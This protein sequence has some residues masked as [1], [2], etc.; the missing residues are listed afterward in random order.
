MSPIIAMKSPVDWLKA[1]LGSTMD[2]LP[3]GGLEL[4]RDNKFPNQNMQVIDESGEP[5][6]FDLRWNVDKIIGSHVYLTRVG[7][8]FPFF[9]QT[10]SYI[11]LQSEAWEANQP[12]QTGIR[13]IGTVAVK[14]PTPVGYIEADTTRGFAGGTYGYAYGFHGAFG[15][16]TPTAEVFF[17][18][19]NS[20]VIPAPLPE[21]WPVGTTHIDLYLRRPG[22]VR[23]ALQ[24]SVEVDRI[25]GRLAFILQGPF[26][27]GS[28]PP[29]TN[30]SG[31]GTPQ[32][33]R[34]SGPQ[35]F[36]D[37][38]E[39]DSE[40]DLWAGTYRFG[41]QLI[42]D[43]G[44][45]LLS[46]LTGTVTVPGSTE[47]Y[48]VR[49]PVNPDGASVVAAASA[50]SASA[51]ARP[52]PRDIRPSGKSA[53]NDYLGHEVDFYESA[54]VAAVNN[55]RAQV[56]HDPLILTQALN[57]AAYRKACGDSGSVEDL[58]RE[59]GY[60]GNTA[61]VPPAQANAKKW[62]SVGIATEDGETVL[63]VGDYLED[64]GVTELY[65]EHYDAQGNRH[66]FGL[67]EDDFHAEV[68]LGWDN[69]S[70]PY[71]RW[72]YSGS[73]P[74]AVQT[75]SDRW[76]SL[77]ALVINHNGGPECAITDGSP[78]AGAI[79]TTYSDGRMIL[80]SYYFERATQNARNA[81]TA[82]EFGHCLG[83]GHVTTASVLN[84]PI[85][86][87]RTTNY[88]TPTSYDT[89]EYN[90]L[91][92]SVDGPGGG[93]GTEPD[94]N[95]TPA[96]SPTGDLGGSTTTKQE[97]RMETRHR[98]LPHKKNSAFAWRVPDVVRKRGG[99]RW[100]PW[101]QIDDVFYRAYRKRWR[102][103]Q[104][105]SF[106]RLDN[107]RGLI[108]I[109]G[110]P[111][112]SEPKGLDIGLTQTD[113][114]TEDTTIIEAPDPTQVP[115]EPEAT[116]SVL[117]VAGLY[118]AA[119]SNVYE[120]GAE[121]IR[122]DRIGLNPGLNQIMNVFPLRTVNKLR[123]AQ[124]S[125]LNAQGLPKEWL[126]I[127]AGGTDPGSFKIDNGV[128]TLVGTGTSQATSPEAYSSIIEW[129]Q[130]QPLT[131]AGVLSVISR[132][133]GDAR[134]NLIQLD[135]NGVGISNATLGIATVSSPAYLPFESHFGPGGVAFDANMA[136]IRL[137]VRMRGPN[138]LGTDATSL[139]LSV[140]DLRILPFG[141]DVRKVEI[142]APGSRSPAD[143]SPSPATP[144]SG[145]AFI[146]VGPVP[147][148]TA[149]E[150]QSVAPYSV[151]NFEDG[152]WPTGWT[153]SSASATMS[154]ET[155]AAL[156]GVNG[157][158]VQDTT[159]FAGG[160][161]F[162]YYD[163]ATTGERLGNRSLARVITRQSSGHGPVHF[164]SI[165]DL[166]RGA[167]CAF[168]LYATG[169]LNIIYWAGTGYK[170]RYIANVS[171]AEVFDLEAVVTGA[172]T[173]NGNISVGFSKNGDPRR[174][175]V[176]LGGVDL[177]NRLAQRAA[178]GV[179]KSEN[180]LAKYN[181][182]FDQG[183]VTRQGDVLDREKPTPPADYVPPPLDAPTDANG[184]RLLDSDGMAKNQLYAFLPPG[185]TTADKPAI[186]P[187]L[188]DP[189]PVK[190]GLSYTICVQSRHVNLSQEA[191][192]GLRVSLEGPGVEPLKV[193]SAHGE[194]MVGTRGWQ[195]DYL[196]FAVPP[197]NAEA[198]Q[199][200]EA[201]TQA[202][203]ELVLRDGVYV[204]Q[205]F[206]HMEGA[207]TAADRDAKRGYAR[208]TS[209][210]F[211][212]ILTRRPPYDRGPRFGTWWSRLGAKGATTALY[213]SSRG[214]T[215]FADENEDPTLVP[216]RDFLR[217]SGTLAGDGREGDSIPSGNIYLE[218]WHGVGTMTRADRSEFP[219][220][221]VIGDVMFEA[222]Y[223]Q[224]STELIGERFYTVELSE[225]ITRLPD[226]SIAVMTEA[227]AQEIWERS[228]RDEF[229]IEAVHA[230]DRV[231]GKLYRVRF[232]KQL[233]PE[234][235]GGS[236]VF[237]A[238]GQ[239]GPIAVPYREI[240]AKFD[241]GM[242]E[243]IVTEVAPLRGIRELI[244]AST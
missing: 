100:V 26:S 130:D 87:D 149:A 112:D 198:L 109:Q 101:V 82:H 93:G 171:P 113:P 122:S 121:S 92:G 139:T 36:R 110:Y 221:A 179:T 227:A 98:T 32:T 146:A 84:T 212:T 192:P 141:T 174:T 9:R 200:G 65:C 41:L 244:L 132:V 19:G 180:P 50:S 169:N 66:V 193:G 156:F 197:V 237:Y 123:N 217:V 88:E 51:E 114:P 194:G 210:T 147:T 231:A 45:T 176:S 39:V 69:V 236:G 89:S 103:G 128:L 1:S 222:S 2:I 182:H 71:M 138:N 203:V 58:A 56:G 205:E 94:P 91:W 230:G 186:I 216:E 202:R 107:G 60:P 219:G 233:V 96:P 137:W 86:V 102:T 140:Q 185:T 49:V 224:T 23:L 64:D 118:R 133:S 196:T 150:P 81:A 223:P 3:D 135:E 5:T 211:S 144:L 33:P 21:S 127:R 125:V 117:P 190:P 38:F 68:S 172:G 116:G 195:D 99:L 115:D 120:G 225:D 17:T 124:F 235:V 162:R 59:E 131:I 53:G 29:A 154:I 239:T 214:A 153:Q 199:R 136:S 77:G 67:E 61:S 108:R 4:A 83:M 46:A 183:V 106:G 27:L 75:A 25:K 241:V 28:P 209:G 40:F 238:D 15:R 188:E 129:P 168:L 18:V 220:L 52:D 240:Y 234:I 158:R 178:L 184:P 208:A 55:S 215:I 22:G 155:G 30:E 6:G 228:L 164:G 20:Q 119:V 151:V 161:G 74:V 104:T 126:L 42:N 72:T 206:G 70:V 163:P 34:I 57:R 142:P 159:Q 105:G 10:T 191:A 232:G 24:R 134:V 173:I 189:L 165:I 207:L 97:Y 47:T 167:L 143:F 7:G 242:D 76:D 13:N 90:R 177:R 11:P 78:N 187:L 80:S 85:Y 43:R 166:T 181:L 229:V 160:Y 213:A 16:T 157:L 218:T 243:A 14:P 35:R 44:E 145:D 31:I 152:L 8:K 63:I 95:P 54:E 111:P 37:V 204:M 62:K 148:G 12:V 201:Y 170:E 79:A 226:F 175:L 73:Y 48:Q